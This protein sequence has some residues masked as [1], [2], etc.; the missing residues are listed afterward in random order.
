MSWI[1]IV[2]VLIVSISALI[3]LLRG[4]VKEFIALVAWI[5]AIWVGI[6]YSKPLAEY[7]PER[8]DSVNFEIGGLNFAFTNLRIGLAF[9]ILIVL[10]LIVGALVN[11][12]IGFLIS[13]GGMSLADRMLGVGFGMAR[14]AVMVIVLV[15]MAGL[16]ELPKTP[17]WKNAHLIKP[18]QQAAVW[19]LRRFP[20]RY[21]E[22]VSFE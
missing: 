15:M 4:F 3:S 21:V 22:K 9:V 13:Q 12:I 16:T 8:I 2:I 11:R 17:W 7:L 20:D 10:L 19:I 6:S 5:I 18:F 14:G 1:D